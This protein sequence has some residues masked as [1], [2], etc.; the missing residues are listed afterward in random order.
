MSP[1]QT[2]VFGWSFNRQ[3]VWISLFWVCF[4]CEPCRIYPM[5]SVSLLQLSKTVENKRFASLCSVYRICFM[6]SKP[7]DTECE[8]TSC[9][10]ELHDCPWNTGLPVTYIV[11]RCLNRG[12][13][14]TQAGVA[15]VTESGKQDPVRSG[16][17]YWRLV[18]V[19]TRSHVGPNNYITHNMVMNPCEF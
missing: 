11:P 3:W 8:Y 10:L 17:G 12:P 19:H 15:T 18:M 9:A 7:S 4:V 5:L 2:W 14:S 1:R 6:N 13:H 16:Q